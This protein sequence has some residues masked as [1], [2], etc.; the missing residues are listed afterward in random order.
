MEGFLRVW[1][2]GHGFLGLRVPTR[3]ERLGLEFRV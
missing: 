2:C 1:G 3:V